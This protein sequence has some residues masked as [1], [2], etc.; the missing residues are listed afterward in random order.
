MN[1][2]QRIPASKLQLMA[3]ITLAVYPLA[4][5]A[6]RVELWHFRNSFLLFVL[7]ALIGFAV[8]VLSVLKMAKDTESK[9]RALVIAIVATALP[10]GMLGH[11]IFK[12][13]NY[14][15]IH[16]I[17]TD[18]VNPPEFVAAAKDRSEGDHDV[19]YE[20]ETIAALQKQGY[21]DLTGLQLPHNAQDTFTLAR[22]AV[23]ELGWQVLAE[24]SSTMP[25][26][27]EA[28]DTSLLFGFKDDVVIRIQQMENGALVDVRSMSRL[29]QSD[30]GVNAQRI[31]SLF[32]QI[33]R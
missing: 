2:L 25:Y 26:T 28:V 21:P 20:G 23:T 32:E 33:G 11:S 9:P 4:I 3:L 31:R 6:A 30:L 24:N 5:V 10:L 15:F 19:A 29:G 16:D 18:T 14:P 17:T 27:I 1:I 22:Q 13:Q 8:L 12:S 7:A